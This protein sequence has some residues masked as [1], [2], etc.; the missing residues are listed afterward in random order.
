MTKRK[1]TKSDKPATV[2]ANDPNDRKGKLKD[3][4]GS[5]SDSWNDVLANQTVQALWFKNSDASMRDQQLSSAVVVL[6]GISPK[7]ELEV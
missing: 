7:D 5:Q 3:I 2:V 1:P 6:T 4:G